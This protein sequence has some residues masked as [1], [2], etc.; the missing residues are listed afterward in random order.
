MGEE[1]PAAPAPAAEE[2]PS[3]LAAETPAAPAVPAPAEEGLPSWMVE[4][5]PAAPAPAEEGLPSWLAEAPVEAAPAAPAGEELPSWLA[6]ETPAAPAEEGLPSWLPAEIPAGPAV[7][8]E[9]LPPWMAA[10]AAAGPPPAEAAPLPTEVSSWLGGLDE[11]MPSWLSAEAPAAPAEAAPLPL[12]LTEKAPPQPA[13]EAPAAAPVAGEMPPWLSA[14]PAPAAAEAAPGEGEPLPQLAAEAAAEVA[15]TETPL[16]WL[17]AEEAA[18]AVPEVPAEPAAG[19]ETRAAPVS[20]EEVEAL[21]GWARALQPEVETPPVPP[22][23]V[24]PPA[25]ERP[26]ATPFFEGLELPDWLQVE[27][28]PAVTPAAAPAGELAWLERL[29]GEEAPA[30]ELPVAEVMEKLPRPTMPSLSAPRLQ[31]AQLMAGFLASPEPVVQARPLRAPSLVRRALE[32]FGS[33]WPMLVLAAV[34]I[35]LLFVINP[36]PVPTVT[37]RPETL[38]AVSV[39]ERNVATGD[40]VVLVAYDW[41]VQ[42]AA[43]MQP[44]ALAVTS[45]LVRRGARIIAVSTVPQGGQLAQD[46]LQEALQ[47]PTVLKPNQEYNYG[48]QYVN[49]GLRTGA[50][51]ALRLLVAQPLWATFPR[52]FLNGK[53][54]A[55]YS[56]IQQAGSLENVTL[57]VVIAGEEDR[58]VAWL[59]QVRTRYP[60][61]PCVL[62]VPAELVPMVQPYLHARTVAPNATLE[63]FPAAVEYGAW[64]ERNEGI[65]LH[66]DLPLEQRQNI[67][68]VAEMALVA[69]IVVGNL[70]QLVSW[71]FGLRKGSSRA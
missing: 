11:E 24:A 1:T 29:A 58:A 17:A 2:L 38:E 16:P 54:S 9:S 4:E 19:E 52:D 15:P 57:L 56:L 10:E 28:Q 49:L 55:S 42:R 39:I 36:F 37:I 35:V 63:G 40:A 70:V 8:A 67:V 14:E 6:A 13:V 31:A 46:V 20:P 68:V 7:P 26:A 27:E 5:T 23:P 71:L 60:D 25:T 21:P 66:T 41:D 33:R 32:W 47:N 3:W 50:E 12:S 64:L 51:S 43:E 18:A 69:F 48:E 22:A 45:H 34:M 61:K 62:V 59:E 44:L 30:E 65:R 53:V